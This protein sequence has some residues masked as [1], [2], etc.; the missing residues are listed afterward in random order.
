M[1]EHRPAMAAGNDHQRTVL[2][3]H[4]VQHHADGG[5]VVVGVRVER[6]IL[7]PF[8]CRAEAGRLHVQLGRVEADVGPP[9]RLQHRDDLRMADQARHRPGGADAPS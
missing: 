8:H 2:H 7:V 5:E 4:V 6:P 1:V 3:L 9:Q